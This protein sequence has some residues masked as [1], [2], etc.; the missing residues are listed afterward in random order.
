MPKLTTLIFGGKIVTIGFACLH[1]A[2]R[3]HLHRLQAYVLHSRGERDKGQWYRGQKWIVLTSLQTAVMCLMSVASG[4]GQTKP[5][6]AETVFKNIQVLRGIPVDEFM[7]TMG[8][9]SASLTLNCTSCHGLESAGD[10]ARFADDTPRK[11]IARKMILMVESINAA[12]FGGK[13]MVTCYTC[14]G[15]GEQ[16][17]VTPSLAQQYGS[18]PPEDPDKFEIPEQAPQAP[19]PGEIFAKYIQALGGSRAANLTSFIAKGTYEGYDTDREKV[20]VE[21]SAKAPDRRSVVV[22]LPGG[23]KITAFDGR[24][25]WVAEPD[26]PAPLMALSGGNLDGA[27]IDATLSF[28]LGIRES[29]SQWKSG[30]TTIDDRDVNVVEATDAQRPAVK[31]YFD[32]GSGLLVRM[33]R[34]ANTVCRSGCHRSRLQRLSLGRRCAVTVQVDHDLGRRAVNHRAKRGTSE[35]AD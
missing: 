11:Q 19:S 17:E 15:G 6:L 27:K 22:H 8:F 31:L 35:R 18:P 20:P 25:G 28:P 34:Y 24:D 21:V 7:D 29:R 30:T 4:R 12:N 13:R 33:V 26:T 10:V 16:P 9:F 1:D 2:V 5:L 23:D 14:H 3:C 32:K